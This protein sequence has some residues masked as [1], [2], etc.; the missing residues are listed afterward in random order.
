M[1]TRKTTPNETSLDQVALAGTIAFSCVATVERSSSEMFD[2]PI[3]CR[4]TE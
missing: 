1:S 3:T 2:R 4:L